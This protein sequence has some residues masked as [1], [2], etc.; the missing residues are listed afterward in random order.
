MSKDTQICPYNYPYQ[1][2][3]TKECIKPIETTETKCPTEHPYF[4]N[5]ICYE[6]KCP[7]LTKVKDNTKFCVCDETKG[8][9]YKYNEIHP[10]SEKIR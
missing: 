7:E 4:F 3:K 8:K 2:F 10:N 6:N 1:I 5:Y 9:W